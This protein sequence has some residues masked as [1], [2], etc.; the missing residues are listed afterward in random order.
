MT[1]ITIDRAVLEQVL[2]AL[3]AERDNYQ[4]WDEEDGAPEYIYESIT[5]LRQALSDSAEQP[6][7][8]PPEL[9]AAVNDALGLNAQQQPAQQMPVAWCDQYETHIDGLRHYSDGSAR[10]VPLYTAPQPTVIDK[11]AAIRIATALGW[12]PK[13]EWVG[14]T[15][16][17]IDRLFE[18]GLG[19]ENQRVIARVIEA[20]LKQKNT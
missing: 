13:R 14:L 3:E 4:T 19:F 12:E 20:E 6:R 5:A 16:E 9:E 15:D 8:A 17:E 10:E 7:P 2:E 18:D 11:S 1:K